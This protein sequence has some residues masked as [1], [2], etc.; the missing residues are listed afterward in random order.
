M[1]SYINLSFSNGI[2]DDYDDDNGDYSI[3]GTSESSM[4]T[5]KSRPGMI[6]FIKKK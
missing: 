5:K 6:E 3:N 1:N 2:V 4:G